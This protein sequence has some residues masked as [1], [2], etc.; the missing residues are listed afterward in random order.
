MSSE[1]IATIQFKRRKDREEPRRVRGLH[2][3]FLAGIPFDEDGEYF[4][5]KRGI[6]FIDPNRHLYEPERH[7]DYDDESYDP[8][9]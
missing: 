1:I 2:D 6:V 7:N 9:G 3:H 5:E 8:Y 4:D